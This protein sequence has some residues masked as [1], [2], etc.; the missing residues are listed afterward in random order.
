MS[1]TR[2]FVIPRNEESGCKQLKS[3]YLHS[4]S[5]FLEMTKQPAFDI[6]KEL[7]K[8]EPIVYISPFPIECP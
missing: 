4:D 2:Y 7:K 6:G 5:S 1:N 3:K 8:K